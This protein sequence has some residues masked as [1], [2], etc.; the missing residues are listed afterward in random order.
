MHT[1]Q[2]VE[3]SFFTKLAGII[4]VVAL[5]TFALPQKTEAK[6]ITMLNATLR[7][8][9]IASYDGTDG[10]TRDGEIS[11]AEAALVTEI[12]VSGGYDDDSDGKKT[13][14][15]DFSDLLNFPNLTI[16]YCDSNAINVLD[17]S[18]NKKLEILFCYNNALASLDLSENGALTSVD[19]AG[20][21]LKSIDISLNTNLNSFA[22]DSNQLSSLAIS[23]PSL[24]WLTCSKNLLTSLDVSKA[25]AL[26]TL[27]C[28]HNQ[29]K[30]LDVS[31]NTAL[32]TLDC[33]DNQ[34]TAIDVSNNLNLKGLYCFR[35]QITELDLSK[36]RLLVWLTCNNNK[37]TSLDV[38]KNTRLRSLYC[39]DNMLTSL[40]ISKNLSLEKIWCDNNRL[41]KLDASTMAKA[42]EYYISCGNQ[43]SD[44]TAI[45][46]LKLTLKDDQ[47]DRW[48][49]TIERSATNAYVECESLNEIPNVRFATHSL[50]AISIEGSVVN[51]QGINNDDFIRVYDLSGRTVASAK[52]HN[53]MAML[54]IPHA[55]LYIVKSGENTQRIEIR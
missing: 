23:N 5:A 24:T 55:G 35:N 2:N 52:A 13:Q 21:K 33:S 6:N 22:C 9:I 48:N 49:S 43:T 45:Q 42:T 34:L 36:N 41:T 54:T 19:C 30:S 7:G 31:K 17:V 18:R 20:N 25:T 26:K 28:K 50:F 39:S 29:I 46:I 15:S 11:D 37:L 53:E 27:D 8:Y 1:R 4:F 16:L 40:D 14:I 47:E 38:S 32:V 3:R 51:I 10:S 12:R 44:G